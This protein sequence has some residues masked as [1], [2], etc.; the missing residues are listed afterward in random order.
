M[1]GVSIPERFRTATAT[2]AIDNPVCD[3]TVK[4]TVNQINHLIKHGAKGIH[5]YSMNKAGQNMRIYN[6]S[7]IAEMRK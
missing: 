3:E 4:Y 1:C 2:C 7:S 6:E 5:L